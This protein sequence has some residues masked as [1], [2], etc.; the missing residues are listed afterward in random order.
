MSAVAP[1]LVNRYPQS[2]PAGGPRP[3]APDPHCPRVEARFV[4]LARVELGVSPR[5]A[6]LLCLLARGV[7]PYREQ[8]AALG[9]S[10]HTIKGMRYAIAQT[11]REGA[12]EP[13][14]NATPEMLLLRAAW[15]LYVRARRDVERGDEPRRMHT[16]LAVRA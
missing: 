13:W 10:L 12:G 11:L 6:Q 15:P 5:Q 16:G 1:S 9:V 14:R 8:M 2:P 3:F 4:R 7:T